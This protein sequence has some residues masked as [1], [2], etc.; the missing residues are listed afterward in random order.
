[1]TNPE[2]FDVF[3]R[4]SR[5]LHLAWEVGRTNLTGLGKSSKN[6]AV[7]AMAERAMA[8]QKAWI[9]EQL[10]HTR[11]EME[12]ATSKAQQLEAQLNGGT[13]AHARR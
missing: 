2:L 12:A 4:E 13:K 9:G 7:R 10:S 5:P 3:E 8:L 11:S 6:P 1:M